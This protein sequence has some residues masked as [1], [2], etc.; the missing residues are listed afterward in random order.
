M[1]RYRQVMDTK[2]VA[3]LL[4]LLVMVVLSILAV[5]VLTM[6]TTNMATKKMQEDSIRAHYIAMSG[7]EVTFGALLQ[8]N[9]S[10]LNTYFKPNPNATP[11]TQEIV[12]DGGS[13]DIVVSTFEANSERWILITSTA[14]IDGSTI[15]NVVTMEFRL[16]Y[17]QIQQ[18]N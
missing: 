13:A 6:F 18:W 8:D 1:K 10:L 2:G 9:E 11:L 14:T 4:V 15:D 16:E 12:F 7:V 5:A 3:L 17:P